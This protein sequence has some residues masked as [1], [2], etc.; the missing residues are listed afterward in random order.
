MERPQETFLA[1]ME[2]GSFYCNRWKCARL[3]S[4]HAGIS[5]C[6]SVGGDTSTE[7]T[8]SD[9]HPARCNYFERTTQA[10]LLALGSTRAFWCVFDLIS[11]FRA[12]ALSGRNF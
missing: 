11:K 8:A 2:R 3:D 1:R 5:L 7:I 12:A 10:A 4:F 6:K 9:R